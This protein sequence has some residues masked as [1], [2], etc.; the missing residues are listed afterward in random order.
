MGE[1]CMMKIGTSGFRGVIGDEFCKENVCKITQ[2]LCDILKKKN[3]KREVVVGYDNRFLSQMF[4]K[5]V[6]EVLCANGV[7]AKL[8]KTSVPSPLVSFSNRLLKNDLSVMITASHNPYYYNGIKIF[9]QN[10]QDLDLDLEQMFEKML[11][12]TNKYKF[13]CYEECEKSGKVEMVDLVKD[14]VLSIKRVMNYKKNI[15]TKTLFNVMNGSCYEC[16]LELK[17]QLK[18]DC[19]ILNTERDISFGFSAPIPNEEKLGEFK[20]L[21]L[22]RKVDFA[23][24]TDGDGD[25]LAVFD[26][27]GNYHNGNDICSL[28]YYFLVKEKKERGAFVKNFSFSTLADKVCEDLKTNIFETAI[29]FKHIAKAINENNG[30]IGGEN[31]GCEV[32]SHTSTKDGLVVFAMLLEI[33]DYYN[34]PL[35]KII[36]DMK[37]E[38]GY[39]LVYKEISL[40]VKNRKKVEKFFENLTFNFEKKVKRIDKLDG[41]K[42]IFSDDTW[43]LVRFSGTENLLRLVTEQKTKRE[44]EKMLKYIKEIVEKQEEK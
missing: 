22:E 34:K 9:S 44:V 8:T 24:A 3:F 36:E 1:S 20:K 12:K 2:C 5:W 26:E 15:G 35:S 23:F 30:L 41:V 13:I 42:F 32:A 43:L 19:D 14:Y 27:I 4:A 18:L 29:G 38:V 28:I 17:N 16:T 33:V 25:R 39:N 40:K 37:K 7:L 31:S 11:K 10:G 6:C 21:A